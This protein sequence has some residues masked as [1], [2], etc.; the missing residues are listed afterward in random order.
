MEAPVG[1]VIQLSFS[2]FD[3]EDHSRCRYDWVEMSYGS[4]S[5]K[6]CGRSNPGQ[7]TSTGRT[8]TVRMHTDGS[9]TR[10]GFRAVWTS[11]VGGKIMSKNYPSTYDNIYDEV[12]TLEPPEGHI[13]QLTFESFDINDHSQCRDDFVE[14]SYGSYREKFCGSSIPGPFTS[15]GPTMTVKIHTDGSVTGTGFRAVW[16]S[17]STNPQG[18]GTRQ[19]KFHI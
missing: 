13:I 7:V 9:V 2:S 16:T 3:L 4:Y 1:H 19:K 5:K 18:K 17:E 15:T 11:S 12:W 8:M 10:T 6:F 14:V